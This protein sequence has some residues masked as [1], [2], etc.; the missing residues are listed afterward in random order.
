MT[1]VE[2][3]Q[4]DDSISTAEMCERLGLAETAVHFLNGTNTQGCSLLAKSTVPLGI[5]AEFIRPHP[6][7]DRLA[8]RTMSDDEFEQWST[9][10]DKEISFTQHWTRVEAYLKATGEGIKGGYLT[11]APSDWTV[12][13]LNV[14]PD[15]C[16]AIAVAAPSVSLQYSVYG[17]PEG[18]R[19]TAV[20]RFAGSAVGSSLAAGMLGLANAL[21]G[22]N[23]EETAVVVN[24][25]DTERD[26]ERLKLE[27]D[28]DDPKA[29]KVTIRRWRR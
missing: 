23:H 10:V 27:L 6:Y 17:I 2:V 25:D 28:P 18:H 7:L 8:R 20:Q 11:R 22:R 5:D 29:S 14:G 16:A 1:D 15:H 4:F 26:D 3:W 24:H 21:E 12:M 9:T 13:E 19:E